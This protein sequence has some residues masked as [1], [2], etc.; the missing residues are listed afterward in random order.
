MTFETDETYFGTSQHLR[1]CGTMGFVTRRASRYPHR[2]VFIRK[3]TPKI[4]MAARTGLLAVKVRTC[5]G[6]KLPW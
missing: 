4:C 5:F 3:W 1:I 2:S 6:K